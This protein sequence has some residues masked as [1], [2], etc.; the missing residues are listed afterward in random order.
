MTDFN[1]YR[2]WLKTEA[3]TTSPDYY[4]LLDLRPLEA[5]AAQ[6][7]AGFQRQAARIAPHLSGERSGLA[8][9][10]MSELAEARVT[11]L[12]PTA[13]RAYDQALAAARQQVGRTAQ[14]K[15]QRWA[16]PA[17]AGDDGLLPPAAIPGGSAPA[18]S[19]APESAPIPQ[20]IPQAMP[21]MAPNM[22]AQPGWQAPAQ[23]LPLAEGYA[24]PYTGYP[25]QPAAQAG[26]NYGGYG[27][28]APQA[29]A[30]PVA[31]EVP[32]PTEPPV[33]SLAGASAGG[34]RPISRRRSSAGPMLAGLLVATAGVLGVVYWAVKKDPTLIANNEVPGNEVPG[35]EVPGNVAGSGGDAKQQGAIRSPAN[36]TSATLPFA[37]GAQRGPNGRPPNP[38]PINRSDAAGSPE[39]KKPQTMDSADAAPAKPA[40]ASKEPDAKTVKPQSAD[41][42]MPA[43]P[44]TPATSTPVTPTPAPTAPAASAPGTSPAPAAGKPPH[45]AM[46]DETMLGETKADAPEAEAVGR[47]LKAALTALTNRDLSAAQEKIDEA[48]LEASAPDT[49]AD[50]A[51]VQALA[52]YVEGFWNAVRQQLAKLEAGEELQI[53]GKMAVVVDANESLI[54]LRRGGKNEEHSFRRLPAKIAVY[55]ARRWLAKGD[56]GT[57]VALAAF[58]LVE[59]NGDLI[60]ARRLIESAQAAGANV[61]PLMDELARREK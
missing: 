19:S 59:K 22:A 46:P 15:K 26:Y 56:P 29:Y 61:Q 36:N 27:Y 12:T 9:R 10:L 58:Y 38:S 57:D 49:L 44:P 55:L 32:V 13:R 25:A 30:A 7:N 35:N 4:A 1:P 16:D 47:A 18:P 51:R 54:V 39:Q 3:D 21:M 41:T 11:L 14:P 2:E 40:M 43:E 24:M 5:D 37:A 33:P 42:A 45:E 50:V 31:A 53:D 28:G 48:T 52:K 8:Q 23:A 60:E 17:G 20:A 34:Y 6:I